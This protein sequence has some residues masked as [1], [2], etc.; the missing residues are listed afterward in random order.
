MI[1]FHFE[2]VS[3]QRSAT[4]A[5]RSALGKVRD[6][7][8]HARAEARQGLRDISI[9]RGSRESPA[10]SP[11]DSVIGGGHAELPG[12]VG[13]GQSGVQLADAIGERLVCFKPG[14]IT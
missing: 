13:Q 9:R 11:H 6:F 3:D 14:T 4:Q 8:C 10:G 1:W 5:H 12:A 2:A 7:I